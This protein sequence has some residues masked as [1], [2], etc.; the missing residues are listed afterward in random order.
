[1][2]HFLSWEREGR[3]RMCVDEWTYP[4]GFNYIPPTVQL[5]M[6]DGLSPHHLLARAMMTSDLYSQAA[7]SVL[8]SMHAWQWDLSSWRVPHP[9][10]SRYLR[11][12]QPLQTQQWDMQHHNISY[13]CNQG[14][15]GLVPTFKPAPAS[16]FGKPNWKISNAMRTK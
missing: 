12:A 6:T 13:R 4:A 7:H 5:E 10:V 2:W 16:Q 11:W 1:M 3:E 9:G 8:G 14:C 15:C